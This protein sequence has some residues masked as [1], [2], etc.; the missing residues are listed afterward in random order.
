MEYIASGCCAHIEQIHTVGEI[1]IQL[2][3]LVYVAILCY[4]LVA[5]NNLTQHIGNFH[6]NFLIIV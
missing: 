4:N 6:H 5:I 2:K 3:L 1:A